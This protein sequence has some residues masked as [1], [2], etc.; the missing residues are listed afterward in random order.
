MDTAAGAKPKVK[1]VAATVAKGKTV[2]VGTDYRG[3]GSIVE[4][5]EA[6]VAFLRER[7][8]L[9]DPE[10]VELLVDSGPTYVKPG[11]QPEPRRLTLA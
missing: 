10:A 9:V 3:P 2:K 11:A 8:F 7:G 5:P 1:L 4:L 6:D